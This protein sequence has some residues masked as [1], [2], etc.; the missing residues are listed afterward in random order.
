[1]KDL[2]ISFLAA[3]LLLALNGCRAGNASIQQTENIE[4][5]GNAIFIPENSPLRHQLT[6]SVAQKEQVK[7]RFVAPASVE[8]DPVRFARIFPPLSGRV[9]RLFVRFGDP[10]RR[11]QLLLTLDSPDFTA[12]E[13]DFVKARSA[14]ELTQRALSRQRDLYDHH[15]AARRDVEQAESD[16]ATANSELER[17]E[18]RLRSLGLNPQAMKFGQ[19]L[20]VYSPI[21]GKVVDLTVGQGEYR[22]DNSAPLMTVADLSTVWL[23]ANVQEKD[24]RHVFKGQAVEAVF[25]AYPEKTFDGKVL[26]VGDLLDPDTRAIKVRVAFSNADGRLKPGMYGAVTF[27]QA[28]K[29]QVMVPT[30]AVF[31]F[32]D[33]SSVF[34]ETKPWTFESRPVVIGTEQEGKTVIKSGLEAGATVVSRQGVLLQ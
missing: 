2:L 20:A 9:Q 11:G 32:G 15:I 6:L 5:Q 24:A 30:S 31:Q 16:Y 25:S 23:T 10:V 28:T 1:M 18:N 21:D 8:A 29:R 26:F 34:V 13:S 14:A 17:S 22:N 33:T 27:A 4:R 12:A 3:G 19:P 7:A